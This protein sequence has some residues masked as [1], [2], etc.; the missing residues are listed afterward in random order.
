MFEWTLIL[1]PA[2]QAAPAKQQMPAGLV[3]V[4]YVTVTF[5]LVIA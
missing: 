2:Q 1:V 4:E 5:Q 3:E